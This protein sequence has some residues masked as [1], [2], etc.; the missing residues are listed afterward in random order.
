M[1]VHLGADDKTRSRAVERVIDKRA[2]SRN[3]GEVKDSAIIE[4]C[5]KVCQELQE[6]GLACKRVFCTSNTNDYCSGKV[7]HSD[8]VGEFAASSLVFTANLPWAVHEITH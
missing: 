7:F 5:L 4:E 2:P 6:A 3:S 8:L 1:A